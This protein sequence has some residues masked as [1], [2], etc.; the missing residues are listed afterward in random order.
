MQRLIV[1]LLIALLAM[2]MVGFAQDEEEELPEGFTT[3]TNEAETIEVSYPEEWAISE[4]DG[5]LLLGSSE[6][7][8]E[9]T[10][11]LVPEADDV[12]LSIFLLPTEFA[13]FI[14]EG[15]DPESETYLEDFATGLTESLGEDEEDPFEF[16]EVELIGDEEEPDIARIGLLNTEIEGYYY[17]FLAADDVLAIATT[18]GAVDDFYENYTDI[19]DAIIESFVFTGTAADLEQ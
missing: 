12:I 17:V 13:G 18:A 4:E 8:L 5:V 9:S 14:V 10:G 1:I 2:P 6:E 3:F 19:S 11:D 16:G 15:V 7:L